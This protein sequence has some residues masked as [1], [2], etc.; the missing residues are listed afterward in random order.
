MQRSG[1]D[2]NRYQIFWEVVGLERGA[3]SLVSTIEELLG[4]KS[5]GSGLE[6]RKHGHRDPWR[7]LR[8]SLYPQKL[9]LTLPTS[10]G[11]S[12]VIVCSR[13][14]ATEFSFFIVQLKIRVVLDVTSCNIINIYLRFEEMCCFHFMVLFFY[15]KNR[16]STVSSVCTKLYGVTSR[17]AVNLILTTTDVKILNRSY[18][19]RDPS[20]L[21]VQFLAVIHDVRPASWTSMAGHVCT[22]LT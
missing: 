17:R 1:F 19:T 8:G 20:S 3:L 22:Q 16:A 21:P 7:W 10:G 5:S 4:R 18:D 12:V 13:T 11:R 6:N 14:Q 15:A 2:S 9:A